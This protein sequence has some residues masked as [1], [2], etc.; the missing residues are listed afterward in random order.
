ML[1]HYSIASFEVLE[2]RLTLVEKEEVF[3]VF[4]KLGNRMKLAGLP[5]NYTAWLIMRASDLNNDLI[6]SSHSVD[7]HK[8]YK[9]H[10]GFMRYRLLIEGQI[11]VV[12]EKVRTLLGFKK[13]SFLNIIL[14]FYKMSRFFK[15]DRLIKN[16]VLP[17]A[18]KKE[19]NQLDIA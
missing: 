5:E 11:L 16:L 3:N 8:Q 15:G 9:K 14:P 19:I 7:L 1:V 18:Y 13:W 10:L 6:K 2:R 4:I 12:P 17:P